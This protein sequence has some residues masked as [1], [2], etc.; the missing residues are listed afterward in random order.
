MKILLFIL[1]YTVSISSFAHTENRVPAL[2]SWFKTLYKSSEACKIQSN[3]VLQK[4]GVTNLVENDYG[5]YGNYKRNRVVVKC[6]EQGH[7]S[8]VWVAVAGM[9]PGSTEL[10]RNIIIKEIN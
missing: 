5:V 4:I 10:L 6:L 7:N 8:I 2:G 1:S 3:Y 9:D